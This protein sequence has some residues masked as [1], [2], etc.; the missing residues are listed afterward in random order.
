MNPALGWGLALGA[1]LFVSWVAY[2]SG[3]ASRLRPVLLALRVLAVM[4]A[5]ALVLD[6]PIG[7]AR[8]PAP[9]VA[10]DASAS[11]VRSGDQ[12]DHFGSIKSRII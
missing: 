7:V 1:G 8:A 12:V 11:W 10:L 2:P 3:A 6:L 4:A 5:V 9:M